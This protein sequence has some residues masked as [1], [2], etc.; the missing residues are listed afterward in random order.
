[1]L[2]PE[3]RFRFTVD[4]TASQGYTILGSPDLSN[5]RPLFTNPAPVFAF[6]NTVADRPLQF[7][8]AVQAR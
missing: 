4:G 1:M 7:F 8:R 5:W 2:L 6:T 3:G